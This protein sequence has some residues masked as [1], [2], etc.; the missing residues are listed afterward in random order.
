MRKMNTIDKTKFGLKAK[1]ILA[2]LEKHPEKQDKLI[3][4]L[5]L[6]GFNELSNLLRDLQKWN[7][8]K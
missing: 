2:D 6:N 1:A 7:G 4:I 3:L 8:G 5:E